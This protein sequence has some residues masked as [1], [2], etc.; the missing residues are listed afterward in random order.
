MISKTKM[1]KLKKEFLMIGNL[2][3]GEDGQIIRTPVSLQLKTS[4]RIK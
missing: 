1:D 2:P 3:G 4:T